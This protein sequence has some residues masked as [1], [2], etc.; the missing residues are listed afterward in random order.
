LKNLFLQVGVLDKFS[1]TEI[2]SLCAAIIT[3]T[4]CVNT[5]QEEGDPATGVRRRMN[6]N[7]RRFTLNQQLQNTN[8]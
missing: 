3:R 4:G 1:K 6:S 2:I 8:L 7:R 5:L